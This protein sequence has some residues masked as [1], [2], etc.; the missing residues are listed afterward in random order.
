N[1]GRY[2]MTGNVYPETVDEDRVEFFSDG[3]ITEFNDVVKYA[4]VVK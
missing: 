3:G 2:V 1:G 4:I